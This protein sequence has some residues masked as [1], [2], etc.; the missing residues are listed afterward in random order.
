MEPGEKPTRSL[1]QDDD[2]DVAKIRRQ[3][4]SRPALPVVVVVVLLGANSCKLQLGIKLNYVSVVVV[5]LVGF[6]SR[7]R[8][9]RQ[10]N[11]A[12]QNW[13]LI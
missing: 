12:N 13:G 2:D 4:E 3:L 1:Q 5:V 8:W 7:A 11:L 10:S 6:A 9:A